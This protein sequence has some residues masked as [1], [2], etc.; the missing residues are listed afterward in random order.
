[1][2]A[3]SLLVAFENS[4]LNGKKALLQSNP[5]LKR[6]S[7]LFFTRV[8][9]LTGQNPRQAER[10]AEG[11]NIV[12]RFGDDP[13]YAWRAKGA[14]ERIRG[15]W[16][17]S[18]KAF[19]QSGNLA[20]SPVERAS[21]QTGAIDGLA[22][23]G[24]TTAAIRLGKS[25]ATKLNE[26]GERSL[27]G[28][29]WLNT[30]NA[31]LWGDHFKE[32]QRCFGLAAECLADSEFKL[33]AASS[34]LGASSSALYID[35]P[36]KSLSLAI[37]ARDEMA[38]LGAS[39][40]SNHAQVNVGQCH[41]LMGEADESVRI[42]S[43]LRSLTDPNSLEY[44]RLGQFLG[45]AWLT[46]QVF[47]AAGDAFLSSINSKGV[48][49][50]PLNFGNCLVGLGDVRLH[51]GD[52]KEA[53]AL[54][55]RASRTFQNFGSLALDNLAK[56]GIARAE[57]K[58]GRNKAAT[59]IL[60]TT[61]HDLRVRRMHHFLVGALL[62]LASISRDN[63]LLLKEAEKLIR[64]FGFLNEAWRIHAIKADGQS[65]PEAAIREYRKMVAKILAYR[66]RLSSV[67]ARTSLVEP[68][69]VSIRSYLNHL[70]VK[71]T[72][73]SAREAL[74]VISDLRSITL[75]DEFLL[76]DS[77]TFSES[78]QHIL[79]QIRK[80]VTAEGGDQLP[81]G[82]LRLLGKGVWNKPSIIR[83]YLEKIGLSRVNKEMVNENIVERSPMNTFVFLPESSAW[84]SGSKSVQIAVTK[85]ELIKRLRWIHFELVAPLSGLK[86]DEARLTKGLKMLIEELQVSSLISADHLLNLSLEDVAYQIPWPLLTSD[87][88]VLH[89]RPFAGI[90]PEQCVLGSD[91]KVAIWYYSRKELPHIDSEVAKIRTLFPKAKIYS[92]VEEILK[93]ADQESFDLIHV[94]AHGR[95]DHENPMFSSIQLQDGHLLACDIARSSFQTRIATLASCDSASMGQPAGWEPQ[96]LARAFLARRSEVVIGSLWPLND[97]AAEFGFASFYRK[98]KEGHSVSAS[99]SQARSD[100]KA[101]FSHPAYWGSLVMF[102]G[103]SK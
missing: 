66:A 103:Y 6:F 101:R 97:Q 55:V 25:I 26:L 40:Y 11:W 102:G 49:Q 90:S 20:N 67:T 50:S 59:K 85:D 75:L 30:G 58:L 92:T 72:P 37:R 70:I 69:L 62:D 81:G 43:E 5:H 74:H 56:I 87:E 80:E 3:S 28:R 36:S 16:D 9:Q 94:A 46:L 33:E 39:A 38:T 73:S 63:D 65:S 14:L 88:P 44:A 96:G 54:Y 99:L 24:K 83:E 91:P 35:L 52:A 77:G 48:K 23:A 29:A 64:R 79:G 71:G 61:I 68:C 31:N 89:L 98:L 86:S 4:D 60:I 34:L 10:L 21:F 17:L 2:E 18:A 41:L 78:A 19:V 12:R 42:F 95:Y 57:I 13:S 84:L 100:L 82:P 15:N 76:A 22:R 93:S 1:M 32:A 8:A 7:E 51:Q 53:K 47:D 45:D 27:A